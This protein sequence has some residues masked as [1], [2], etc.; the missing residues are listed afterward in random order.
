M[1]YVCEEVDG[2]EH[3]SDF[4]KYSMSVWNCLQKWMLDAFEFCFELVYQQITHGTI[5]LYY[6]NG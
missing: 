5:E 3:H 4:C 1:Y 2:I 6:I